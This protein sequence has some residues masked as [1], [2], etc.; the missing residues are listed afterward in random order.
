MMMTH[1]NWGYIYI[2]IYILRLNIYDIYICIMYIY[3]E[4]LIFSQSHLRLVKQCH[5]PAIWPYGLMVY[6][7][8]QT[9]NWASWI[10]LLY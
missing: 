7:P 3:I 2:Y 9:V 10:L 5:K 1:W 4:Y 6:T 8:H